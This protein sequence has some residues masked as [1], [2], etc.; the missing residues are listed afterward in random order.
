MVVLNPVFMKCKIG[1]T[2]LAHLIYMNNL[3]YYSQDTI[4]C[5]GNRVSMEPHRLCYFV[6]TWSAAVA[7]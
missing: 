5:L 6:V 4:A 7:S 1:I 2:G 3:D